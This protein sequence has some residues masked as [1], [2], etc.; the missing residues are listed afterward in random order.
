MY[1]NKIKVSFKKRGKQ[2]VFIININEEK[3]LYCISYQCIREFKIHLFI[4]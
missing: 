1:D 3:T 4:S 2:A